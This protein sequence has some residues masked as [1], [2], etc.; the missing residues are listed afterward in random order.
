LQQGDV[1]LFHS[2]LF[3]SAGRNTGDKVKTSVVFAYHGES[4]APVAG[5]RSAAAGNVLLGR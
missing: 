5:T 2:G 3:H 1:L 4:N